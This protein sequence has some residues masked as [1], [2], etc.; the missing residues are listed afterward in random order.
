MSNQG[1]LIKVKSSEGA[2]RSKGMANTDALGPA[3]PK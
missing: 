3:Y 2:R 1:P